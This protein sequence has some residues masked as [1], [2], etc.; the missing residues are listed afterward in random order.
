MKF[1]ECSKCVHSG[2]FFVGESV[3]DSRDP[4]LRMKVELGKA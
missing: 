3:M 1:L 2:G 4:N